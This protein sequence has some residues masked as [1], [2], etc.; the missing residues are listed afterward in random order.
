MVLCGMIRNNQKWGENKIQKNELQDNAQTDSDINNSIPA[1]DT[2]NNST[3]QNI[4]EQP[5]DNN[6]TTIK[7]QT[8]KAKS[9][10]QRK[11]Q[12]SAKSKAV[13]LI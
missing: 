6:Q 10:V 2:W 3:E 5:I 11:K 13:K 7:K 12:E 8:S 9:T 4:E 1:A